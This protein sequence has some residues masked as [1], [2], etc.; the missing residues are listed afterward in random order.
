MANF[1]SHFPH[2][3]T[4]RWAQHLLPGLFSSTEKRSVWKTL[5]LH[6]LRDEH[7]KTS[8]QGREQSH[9]PCILSVKSI[10][11]VPI[12]MTKAGEGS[13]EALS[14]GVLQKHKINYENS[15]LCLRSNDCGTGDGRTRQINFQ[16]SLGSEN[17]SNSQIKIAHTQGAEML[18]HDASW[19]FQSR[20]AIHTGKK[21]VAFSY[22]LNKINENY[23]SAM[24]NFNS[25]L[26]WH[27]HNWKSSEL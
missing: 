9:H 15:S 25:Q 27:C 3:H 10:T 16:N 8:V 11:F 12:R 20:D 17:N 1:L 7:H 4:V 18:W 22:I 26:W 5:C 13:G 23:K 2:M 21:S 6:R 24:L 14:W 19:G